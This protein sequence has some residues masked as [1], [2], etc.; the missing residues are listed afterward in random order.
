MEELKKFE[1]NNSALD[2]FDKLMNYH[3]DTVEELS[4]KEFFTNIKLYNIVSLC[5]NLKTLIVEGDSRIDTNK[6]ISNI[7]KPELLE[8]L[9]F[10]SVKLPTSKNF[11][12]FT[13]LR[14]ISLTNIT[15]S[16]VSAFLEKVENKE[17]VIALN[18]S[19]S[20][21]GKKSINV[22]AG[23]K[24]LKYFNID[25]LKNCKFDDFSFLNNNKIKRFD[26]FENEIGLE[27]VKDLI[28]GKY[29]KNID[30]K[31]KT[32]KK[33]PIDNRFEINENSGINL[34]LNSSN[35]EEM[36]SYVSL[37]KV[38]NLFL[39]IENQINIYE[40]IRKLRKVKS[41]LTISLKN[42]SY[43]NSEVAQDLKDKL[44]I[45]NIG[46]IDYE[47]NRVKSYSI[48]EYIEIRKSFDEIISKLPTRFNQIDLVQELYNYLKLNIKYEKDKCDIKSFFIE[49]KSNY[50][51]YA[52]V[53]DTILKELK[54]KCKIISGISY[55]EP[56]HIWNQVNVEGNWYNIDLGG[57]LKLKYNKKIKKSSSKEI[58]LD[59][60]NFLKNHIVQS[61]NAEICDTKIE[62]KKKELKNS[63]K[64]VGIFKRFINKIKGIF[65]F[66]KNKALNAPEKSED[67]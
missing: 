31:I 4:I 29:T 59:D 40:Y 9:I 7:C 6:I 19:N 44:W 5:T 35:L 30:V 23:F 28:K 55:N 20:D 33:S 18:L 64:K 39:V 26:F 25:G 51:L 10:N 47:T 41:K 60:E 38:D 50:N 2:D 49:N 15:F 54:I 46:V 3:L 53:I 22:C 11:S 67:K 12:K 42:I 16:S 37:S 58:F 45:E 57:E 27:Q 63:A 34:T 17:N 43:L 24:N 14:T 66:N 56:N 61:K 1:L 52:I 65:K 62:E 32:S 13:N 36:I 21:M 48:D 8:T